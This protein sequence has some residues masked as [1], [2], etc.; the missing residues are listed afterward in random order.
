MEHIAAHVI[1]QLAALVAILAVIHVA[2]RAVVLAMT[3]VA[4]HAVVLAMTIV[5]NHAVVLAVTH[6]AF[7]TVLL[8][9]VLTYAVFRAALRVVVPAANGV[10]R[11]PSKCYSLLIWRHLFSTS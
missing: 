8:N 11:P 3:I 5:A 9:V 10:L 2:N 6:V 1:N 7:P 4:N